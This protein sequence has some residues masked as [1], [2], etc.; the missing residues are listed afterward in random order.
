MDVWRPLPLA[1]G[2]CAAVLSVFGPRNAAEIARVLS[3]EGRL[4]VV[5]PAPDHLAE[6]I[7]PLG[8]LN[9][10]P[11]KAERLSRQLAGFTT[12]HETQV[13]F[14]ADLTRHDVRHQ[15]LM[16]PTAHHVE[17]AELD[18]RLAELPDVTQTTV[19]VTVATY[20]LT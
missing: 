12:V 11:D 1:T 18:R 16:G 15:V 17:P 20:R 5:S 7:G 19:A 13:R 6:I 8:M 4:I 2:S 14:V 10:A 3:P 9:V